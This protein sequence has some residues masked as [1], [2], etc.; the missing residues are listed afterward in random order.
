MFS[1]PKILYS[2]LFIID[3]FSSFL[4]ILITSSVVV[5][6]IVFRKKEHKPVENLSILLM[7][8][9]SFSAVSSVNIYF[10]FVSVKLVTISIYFFLSGFN[11]LNVKYFT[12][13]SVFTGILLYGLTL[14][15]GLAG[16]PDYFE[17]GKYFSFNEVNPLTLSI[18]LIMIFAGFGF[19]IGL[20]PFNFIMPST[21]EKISLKKLFFVSVIPVLTLT[22]VLVRL[23]TAIFHDSNFVNADLQFVQIV[24]WQNL[25]AIISTSSIIT[26]SLIILW[27]K[28]LKKIFINLLLIQSGFI[29]LSLCSFE[30]LSSAAVVINMLHFTLTSLGIIIFMNIIKRSS[31]ISIDDIKGAGFKNPFLSTSFII[32]LLSSAGMPLTIGFTAKL[33]TISQVFNTGYDI[34]G[35]L[36]IFSLLPLLYFVYKVVIILFSE[37]SVKNE[38]SM[39]LTDKLIMLLILLITIISGVFISPLIE[40]SQNASKLFLL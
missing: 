18:A 20:F 39:E 22:G 15:H 9:G 10:T 29:L 34:A 24:K 3:N 32:L 19:K 23:L 31:N 30:K 36:V 17:I 14:L 2:G 21:A 40:F 1:L 35:I 4:K 8:L 7:L 37:N 13:S 11:K 27:Q 25:V 5:I 16:S 28:E 33:Y 6:F 12:Y 38:Y 26:G